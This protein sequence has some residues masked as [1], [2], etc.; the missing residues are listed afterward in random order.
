VA[1]NIGWFEDTP[2]NIETMHAGKVKRVQDPIVIGK[3]LETA[4]Q[5]EL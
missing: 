3:F 2:V 5:D 1:D 4:F